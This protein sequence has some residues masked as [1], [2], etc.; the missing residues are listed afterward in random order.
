MQT[1]KIQIPLEVMDKATAPAEKLNRSLRDMGKSGEDAAKGFKSASTGLTELNSALQLAQAGMAALKKGYDFAK[2]GA[3]IEFTKVKFD[4]LAQTIGTTG[5]SLLKKLRPVTRGVM[6]DMELI[7]SA[8]DTMSL[9]LVRNERD[10]VLLTSVMAGLG[11]DMNQVVLALSNQTTMRFDQLGVAVTGFD[12]KV[13]A[14][15]ETGMDA[16]A[17][18]TEAFLQQAEEQLA[19]V[20]HAADTTAG[21]FMQLEAS[22][23]NFTDQLKEGAAE[24]FA[25]VIEGLNDSITFTNTYYDALEKLSAGTGMTVRELRKMHDDSMVAQMQRGIAATE[26]YNR[27][28]QQTENITAGAVMTQEQFN[29]SMKELSLIMTD[30][31]SNAQQKYAENVAELSEKLKTAK[32][33]ERGGIIAQIKEE[34]AAYNERATAIM[35]NIQQQAIMAAAESGQIDF[36]QAS[37]AITTLA[38]EYGMIDETQRQVMESTNLLIEQ[39]AQTGN[40]ENFTQGLQ[41]VTESAIAVPEPIENSGAATQNFADKLQLVVE[42]L[43]RLPPSGTEW[44]YTFSL[45]APGQTGSVVVADTGQTVNQG[46]GN[47]AFEPKATGGTMGAGWTMVGERGAELISPSGY[48]YTHA[49]SAAMMRGGLRPQFARAAGGNILLDGE[50]NFTPTNYSTISGTTIN[51][52]R[53]AEDVATS[54]AQVAE[55]IVAPVVTSVSEIVSQQ[56]TALKI[57]VQKLSTRT[58]ETNAILMS[59]YNKVASDSGVGRAVVEAQNKLS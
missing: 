33:S 25:P 20:G 47:P 19:K 57:E 59:I 37:A 32:E 54:F 52:P 15:K 53:S 28:L 39:F 22:W 34:T 4:R 26:F 13:K 45:A 5:D 58:T 31:L 10:A 7:A 2:E 42:L 23:K 30:D 51:Q 17:A 6:S 12:D 16:N 50:M 14:L 8:T 11:M 18:F 35:F 40:L 55:A 29:V 1:E 27:Q 41:M 21:E 9:G 24:G 46:T 3:Q 36:S 38:S 56:Q 48:V 49:Q 44:D 43:G